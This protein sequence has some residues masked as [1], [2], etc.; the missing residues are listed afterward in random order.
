MPGIS[1]NYSILQPPVTVFQVT[2]LSANLKR[3][4]KLVWCSKVPEPVSTLAA[5]CPWSN[6]LTAVGC[7]SQLMINDLPISRSSTS[8]LPAAAAVPVADETSSRPHSK[9]AGQCVAQVHLIRYEFYFIKHPMA[10]FYAGG[11][12]R[13]DGTADLWQFPGLLG[14]WLQQT[15]THQ[16]GTCFRR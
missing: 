15:N 4:L 11:Y 1:P 7:F 9:T 3:L 16:R 12:P 8:A 2:S 5:C 14:Y 6:F 10:Y 13:T